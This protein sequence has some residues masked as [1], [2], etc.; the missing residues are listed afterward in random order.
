MH[1]LHR[2]VGLRD[3]LFA[4][5]LE[6]VFLSACTVFIGLGLSELKKRKERVRNY[7]LIG[8]GVSLAGVSLYVTKLLIQG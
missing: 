7:A 4:L 6:L 2:E 3:I 8:L 5:T 1:G